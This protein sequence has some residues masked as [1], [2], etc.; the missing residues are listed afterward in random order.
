MLSG[1][2]TLDTQIRDADGGQLDHRRS[3]HDLHLWQ[4]REQ[5]L[6]C[7]QRSAGIGE[8]SRLDQRQRLVTY[9]YNRIGQQRTIT[10]QRGTVRTIYYNKLERQ[11]NDCV[12]TNGTG[13]D[14]KVKQIA[15]AYEVRGMA[16]L[17]TS[18]DSATQNSGPC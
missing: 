10:D 7:Q 5:F 11:T 15:T 4:Q 12:T 14:V 13:T 3:D 2:H 16:S 9:T 17:I 6:G 1:R 18:Y 8:V